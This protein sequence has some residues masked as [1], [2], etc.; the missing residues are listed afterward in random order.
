MK[1]IKTIFNLLRLERRDITAIYFYAILNGIVQLSIPLGIQ[2]IINFMMAQTIRASVWVLIFL[3][4]VAVVIGGL[5]QV[6]Q[7]KIIEK[8][9]Q[10]LFVRN[11]YKFAEHLPSID[12]NSMHNNYTPEIVNYFFET[13]TLQK[14]TNKLLI[15]IPAASIQIVFGLTI[16]SFYSSIFIAFGLILL[17]VLAAILRFTGEAGL[18]TSIEESNFKY[19]VAFWLQE[20]GRL[21]PTFKTY[22]NRG[23]HLQKTTELLNGYTESRTKH[24]KILLIQ[25]WTL[26][27]FKIIITMGMLVLGVVLLEDG[28][29]NIGQF[30]A[31]E[32]II[33]ATIASVEKFM[34]SLEN[35][36]DVL[37][38]NDK[39]NK[40][41][42]K[43]LQENGQLTIANTT[44][45]Y[46]IE[47]KDLSFQFQGQSEL[48][49]QITFKVQA[50]NI[51]TI[52]GESGS[53]KSL[54]LRILAGIHNTNSGTILINQIPM[55]NFNL[56]ALHAHYG[57]KLSS[58][59]IFAGNIMQ[60]I[61]M[62]N[63][64]ITTNKIME[65]ASA[66]GFNDFIANFNNG[67]DE[68]VSATG[69]QLS[70]LVKNQILILRSL[71][72]EPNVILLE[73]PTDGLP[74][75]L[76]DKL[77]EYLYHLKNNP[78]IIC[79]TNNPRFIAKSDIQVELKT[80]S[81]SYLGIPKN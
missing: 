34:L 24:F 33:I 22:K 73:N 43:P 47:V 10:I 61:V 63:P 20:I 71:V 56:D 21:L 3:V 55:H 35:V 26:N 81:I 15:D 46:A 66:L 17:L 78:T 54:L 13:M 68:M 38:A 70:T 48:L 6:N 37:T 18:K 16:L 2:S 52:T 8:I 51:A 36:Y 41:L 62:G 75:D 32:F 67:L 77:I 19:K 53:G 29:I 57:V 4:V 23:F 80:G 12:I 25:F 50:G 28:Q 60:N 59:E 64:N 40:V 45:G 76:Q 72:H 79:V 14:G 44:E 65:V 9:Q 69:K 5:L 49:K 74:V 7:L 31:A 1:A 11:G 30:V 42:D 27:V 39:L 58:T